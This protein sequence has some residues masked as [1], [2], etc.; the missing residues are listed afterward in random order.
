MSANPAGISVAKSETG[1][2][3]QVSD[4]IRILWTMDQERVRL[5]GEV[6]G[7]LPADPVSRAGEQNGRASKLHY[8]YLPR[9]VGGL[10]GLERPTAMMPCRPG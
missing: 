5:A 4:R 1:H 2:G 3:H 9:P 6:S 7:C 10:T 8:H